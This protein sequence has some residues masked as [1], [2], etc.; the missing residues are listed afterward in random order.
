MNKLAKLLA[1]AG[2]ATAF[3][4]AFAIFA[5]VAQA[6]HVSCGDVLTSDTTLDADLDCTGMVDGLNI[7]TMNVTLDLGGFTLSGDPTIG[8][9]VRVCCGPPPIKNVTIKNGIIDGFER[10]VVNVRVRNLKLTHLVFTGQTDASLSA[11]SLFENESVIIEHSAFLNTS[12]VTDPT[13]QQPIAILVNRAKKVV[14]N[15]VDV[16]DYKQ[17]VNVQPGS[18]ARVMNSTFID[19]LHP[20][21]THANVSELVLSA[22]HMSGCLEGTIFTCGSIFVGLPS[23]AFPLG[24][25]QIENNFIHDGEDGIV[26]RGVTNAKVSGNHVRD[27][28][29]QGISLRIVSTDNLI[30]SNLTAGNG[31]D[32]QHEASSTPNTWVNNSCDT[33]SG[34]DIDC[35]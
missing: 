34:A 26:L 17:G 25:I 23:G 10:Q 3:V 14:I 21:F 15:N 11:V 20:V 32:L 4:L 29:G 8:T 7:N 28:S 22:N 1:V 6:I 27:N 35:P 30:T 33:S 5:Q 31:V 18:V 16:H 24:Q 19:N 9:G 13:D 12:D 2:T